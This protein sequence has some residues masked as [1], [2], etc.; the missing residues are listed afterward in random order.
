MIDGGCFISAVHHAIGALGIAR[1]EAITRPLGLRHQF[2]KGVHIT[3]V[4]EITRFLPAKEGVGGIA[5]WRAIELA[6][7][8]QELK[9]E[10]GLVELPSL[11]AVR[12]QHVEQGT[13]FLAAEEVGLIGGSLIGI[14]GAY[15]HALDTSIHHLVEQIS[16][17]IGVGTFEERG[18]GRDAIA[19]LDGGA[20]SDHGLVICALPADREVVVVSRAVHVDREREVLG[21]LKPACFKFL[22]Q[23]NG[24]GAEVDVLLAFHQFLHEFTD[25]AVQQWFAPRNGDH[26]GPAFVYGSEGLVKGHVLAEDVGW[27]LDLATPGA[28]Q[29]AAKQRLQH[30]DQGVPP[31]A[32]QSLP[33]YITGDSPHLANRYTHGQGWYHRQEARFRAFFWTDARTFTELARYQS[34]A[35][36]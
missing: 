21:G 35:C 3:F 7:A 16:D 36:H 1:L 13:G 31:A 24:V 11:P 33:Q 22:F 27:I 34:H 15:R 29:I 26:G 14:A 4:D 23:E 20:N 19:H 32:S 25:G 17:G 30:E 6:F 18:I 28:G 2:V 10:H 8:H 12:E 5:P 9:E